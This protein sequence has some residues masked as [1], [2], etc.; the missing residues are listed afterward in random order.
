MT[1]E[2]YLDL[3]LE[4]IEVVTVNSYGEII[5]RQQRIAKYLIEDLS[6][7]ITLEMAKI[8]GGTFMMG[9]PEGEGKD[10]EKPQHEVN[11]QPFFMGKFPI[12]QAQWKAVVSFPKAKI[13]LKPDPDPSG[14]KG[15]NY[16]VENIYWSMGVEFCD[17]ATP[18]AGIAYQNVQKESIGY[19]VK[20]N[21][22]MDVEQGLQHH[23]TLEKQL[24]RIWLTMM[25]MLMGMEG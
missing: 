3:K 13:D 1:P 9:S 23:F 7:G 19:P 4:P 10:N 2:N 5:Q 25:V 6:D 12:T 18:A 15:A 21:G 20:P 11:I 8:P 22:N 14:F 24:Q 16:P 17:G